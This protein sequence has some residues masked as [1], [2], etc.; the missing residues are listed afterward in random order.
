MASQAPARRVK[1]EDKEVYDHVGQLF[2]ADH[3]GLGKDA[4]LGLEGEPVSTFVA[5]M[6]S[7]VRDC[8]ALP[9]KT[10][11]EAKLALKTFAGAIKV[12]RCFS[13]RSKEMKKA[14]REIGWVHDKAT[15]HRPESHGLIEVRVGQAEK[16]TRCNLFQSKFLHK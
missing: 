12:D 16:A 4:E 5:A 3:I 11:A 6:Y 10:A 2:V 1:P 8:L 15:P 14:A 13:D 9:N 7:D